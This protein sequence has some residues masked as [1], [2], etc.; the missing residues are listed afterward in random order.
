MKVVGGL[1]VGAVIGVVL[2][3]PL[4]G[5]AAVALKVA[6]QI[7]YVGT[8]TTVGL[9]FGGGCGSLIGAKILQYD[10]KSGAIPVGFF[11]GC[12]AGM[13]LGGSFAFGVSMSLLV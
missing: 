1:M 12:V 9:L 13:M 7:L 5:T 2:S 11:F 6:S 8:I 3:H 10:T 4:G